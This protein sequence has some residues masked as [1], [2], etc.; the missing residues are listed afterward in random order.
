MVDGWHD[1]MLA[2]AFER[3]W[4]ICDAVL[5][6]RRGRSCA[7][8]P[9]HLRW[10]WDGTPLVGR[11]V[12]VRCYHGLGDT[13]QFIRFVP[14]LAAVAQSVV[15]EAQRELLPLLRSV[16]DGVRFY[17]LDGAL[18][19]W[20]VAIE[21]MELPHALRITLGD[22]PGHIPYLTPPPTFSARLSRARAGA[23]R[24]RVGV[25]WAAGDWRRERSLPPALLLPLVALPLDLFGLQLGAARRDTA[26]TSL[27][28]SL[29]A[30]LPENA[31]I[32]DTAALICDLDLVV[33]VDTMVAHLAG[34]LGRPVWTLLDAAADW[35][36]MHAR[37]DSPW[38]PTMRLFRQRRPGA[39]QPVV[40]ELT[41]ALAGITRRRDPERDPQSPCSE[42]DRL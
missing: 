19:S 4:D 30:M 34:A 40:A 35:R 8:L 29:K 14:P 13:L 10:V 16:C 23:D 3:A 9:Y 6:G 24:P 15:V 36:W 39:W 38:Y 33:S 27:V 22:L 1:A 25:V 17:P 7:D 20:D 28:S 12:L 18:P 5:H 26:A 32:A 42:R 21:S 2:G 31:T 11:R 37:S 41:A